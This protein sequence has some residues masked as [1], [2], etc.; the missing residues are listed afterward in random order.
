MKP[1]FTVRSTPVRGTISVTAESAEPDAGSVID[2]VPPDA[3]SGTTTSSV[4]VERPVRE[5]STRAGLPSV[6]LSGVGRPSMRASR[7]SIPVGT[8]TLAHPCFS[9]SIASRAWPVTVSL[10]AAD[11]RR[12]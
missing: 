6:T 5:S 10:P 9:T 2:S 8:C 4:S 12:S 11:T 3:T 7:T 1:P